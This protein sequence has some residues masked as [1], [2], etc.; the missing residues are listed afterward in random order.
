MDHFVKLLPISG[1]SVVGKGSKLYHVSYQADFNDSPTLWTVAA[2]SLFEAYALALAEQDC[3]VESLLHDLTNST[4][5]D[6]LDGYEI[7]EVMGGPMNC[8]CQR[9]EH[10]FTVVAIGPNA[11]IMP[12][13][14]NAVDPL[15][16]YAAAA[17]THG[18]LEF[19]AALPSW[20]LASGLVEFP[21]SAVVD[22]GTVLQQP[23][24]FGKAC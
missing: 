16:A 19:V 9:I 24:V 8:Q 18:D 13:Q 14:V 7:G 12:V 5:D 11:Q 2:D 6:G 21:G 22:A 10:R 17:A 20:I 15:S 23:E 3:A 1:S 4:D